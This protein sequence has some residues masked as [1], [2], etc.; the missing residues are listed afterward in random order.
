MRQWWS[1]WWQSNPCE[2]QWHNAWLKG[3]TLSWK[4]DHKCN[5]STSGL[6]VV[7]FL[8]QWKS[9]GQVRRVDLCGFLSA[10]SSLT[11]R[12]VPQSINT[13]KWQQIGCNPVLPTVSWLHS[14]NSGDRND[15][16]KSYCMHDHKYCTCSRQ[17][18]DTEKNT[19]RLSLTLALLVLISSYLGHK[20]FPTEIV[21]NRKCPN[22][23]KAFLFRA[24]QY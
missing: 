3:R 13:G 23:N 17:T 5:Q 20:W 9:Q 7:L 18:R 24:W 4:T 11:P 8:S 15:A 22:Q 1:C 14:W 21:A 10:H 2:E 16:Q 19:K 6:P 12:Q